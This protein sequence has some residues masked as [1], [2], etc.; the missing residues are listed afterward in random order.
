MKTQ[1]P[2][3]G[4]LFCEIYRVTPETSSSVWCTECEE[5]LQLVQ[6]ATEATLPLGLCGIA[7]KWHLKNHWMLRISYE[8]LWQ[9]TGDPQ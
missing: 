5:S 7:D 1:F 2:H 9:A 3:V 8:S 6:A 4:M